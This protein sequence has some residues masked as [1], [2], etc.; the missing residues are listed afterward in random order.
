[1]IGTKQRNRRGEGLVQTAERYA[2][3]AWWKLGEDYPQAELDDIWKRVLYNQFHDIL[4]GSSIR[5]GMEGTVE[6]YGYAFTRA[7][8]LLLRTQLALLATRRRRHPLPLCVLN[9]HAAACRRVID[10]E[11]MG[12]PTPSAMKGKCIRLLDRNNR[13]VPFQLLTAS[14]FPF[15]RKRI[16]FEA[17]LPALGLAEYRIEIAEGHQEPQPAAIRQRSANGR[18]YLGTNDYSVALDL[19]TGKL[20][21]WRDKRTGHELLRSPGARLVAREDSVDAWGPSN[22]PYGK[23]VGTFRCPGKRALHELVGRHGNPLGSPVRI[24]ESGP[25]ATIV[26]VVQTWAR[27]VA[28]L[29][30]TFYAKRPEIRLELLVN[31][32]ERR[33]ALQLCFPTVLDGKEYTTEIPYGAIRRPTGNSEEP[34]GRWTMLESSDAKAAFGL[35]NDGPGGGDVARGELRQTI[36]RSPAFCTMEPRP[37]VP[38]RLAEHMDLGE[39]RY[40]FI[41]LA[42]SAT[43]VRHELPMLAD[44]L[45]IPTTAL[46][47]LPLQPWPKAGI[48]AGQDMVSVS[49]KSVQLGALKQSEDGRALIVRLI[50]TRGR[51]ARCSVRVPGM[52]HPIDLRLGRYEIRTL[53]IERKGTRCTWRE[54]DLRENL[55][56]SSI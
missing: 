12:A 51:A 9:P 41:L 56:T 38:D 34:C 48:R 2:A 26:E 16:L 4:P 6:L 44:E 40:E 1:V 13:R 47:H 25:I 54:C 10:I 30:Y 50:E 3:L 14:A 37:Y 52:R 15:W 32:S 36:V 29:R 49:G 55:V 20:V 39:H 5:E 18:L 35:V 22:H 45:T 43:R 24:V 17:Q 42:G 21:S 23:V 11:F 7:R 33:H 53:C 28:R 46:V 8:E 19:R 31:W 27:S